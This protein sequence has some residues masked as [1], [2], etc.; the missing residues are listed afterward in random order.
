DKVLCIF[1]KKNKVKSESVLFHTGDMTA[2]VGETMTVLCSCK[3][4]SV[5][6][7]LCT[8]K[9]IFKVVSLD[10]GTCYSVFLRCV[11]LMFGQEVYLSEVGTPTF[12]KSNKI[13]VCATLTMTSDGLY[14]FRHAG[15]NCTSGT[16]CGKYCASNLA[17][18]LVRS[19]NAGT[20]H[21]ALAS[22]GVVVFGGGTKIEIIGTWSVP[23]LLVYCLSAALALSIIG[24]L[25]LSSFM[26]KLSL[27]L[28]SVC[29]GSLHY[30]AV[31]LRRS[32]E[33]QLQGDTEEAC[34]YSRVETKEV[35]V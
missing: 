30:A 34:V 33:Q 13:G 32:K 16:F 5:N 8:L 7:L 25:V 24:V 31:N 21:C 9:N 3:P 1:F 4:N 29:E 22:C 18:D 20:Y 28:K 2:K 14:W 6:Y 26:Y 10:S 35:N 19:S 27:K 11:D 17:L 12:F 15:F 23:L